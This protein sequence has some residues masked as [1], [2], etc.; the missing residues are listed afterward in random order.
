[1]KGVLLRSEA[2][3]V[4]TALVEQAPGWDRHS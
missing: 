3:P 4:T 1:L 2:K